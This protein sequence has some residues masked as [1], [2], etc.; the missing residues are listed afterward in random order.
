MF[1][2]ILS[3]SSQVLPTEWTISHQVLSCLWEKWGTPHIDLFATE[4]TH[5]LP[6][7][8]SPVRDPQAYAL[9]AFSI[10]WTSLSAYAYPPT[11]L[12]PAVIERFR[13]DQPRLILVTPGWS[14]RPWYAELISLSHE[15]PLPLLLAR[16]SLVQPRTGVCHPNPSQL[17]L[18]G[19]LLCERGCEHKA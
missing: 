3:R 7:Y 8:V 14:T 2:Q 5:R 16:G 18:Q 19:W 13:L 15:D 10:P 9:N 12:I 6:V 1:W 11:A 4:F 17:S